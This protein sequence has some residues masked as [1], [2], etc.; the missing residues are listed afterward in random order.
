L[1][2]QPVAGKHTWCRMS[3]E[4]PPYLAERPSFTLDPWLH[5]GGYYVQEASSMFLEQALRQWAPLEEPLKVLDLC[6][7]PGGKSTHLLSLLSAESVLV[8]NE[9]I[10]SRSKVLAENLSKWGTDQ[11]IVTSLD[12][13]QFE[14]LPEAFDVVVVDAPCSGEGLMRRDAA[15]MQEWSESHVQLCSERQRRILMDVWP[16]LK[17]GGLL[18]Y[19]TCTFNAQENEANLAWLH[20][21]VEGESLSLDVPTAWGIQE[22]QQ[23]GQ[24]GYGLYPH[25]LSGE[26]LFLAGIRKSGEQ[27][28]GKRG[29]K[30]KKQKD[31]L[32]RL[33]KGKLAQITSWLKDWERKQAFQHQDQWR[34]LPELGFPILEQ[35]VQEKLSIVSA[36]LHVATEKGK[37][38]RPEQALATY[39]GLEA[40]AFATQS[41]NREEAIAYLRRETMNLPAQKGWNLLEYQS[42]GLGWAKVLPNR[43][44]NYYPQPWRIRM[45]GDSS[46]SLADLLAR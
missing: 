20:T 28:V 14:R 15:A 43:V 23:D 9:I 6:A 11:A 46:W 40:A 2:P 17:P 24:I 26:G 12:P 34:L 13:Q 35:L 37:D 29:K 25:K 45:S 30:R 41:L 10:R 44:N 27:T 21:Q 18:I 19:S 42:L 31:N 1:L 33:G 3:M 16:S 38:L 7:A 8:S 5:A 36:G 22:L 4:R 39:P 32:T